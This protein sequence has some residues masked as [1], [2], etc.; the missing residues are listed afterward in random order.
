MLDQLSILLTPPLHHTKNT[1]LL[2]S[3][4]LHEITT[5]KFHEAFELLDN[6]VSTL[7]KFERGT[8]TIPACPLLM[9][10]E[11]K[12]AKA[13]V[14]KAPKCNAGPNTPGMGFTT[15]DAQCQ[16]SGKPADATPLADDLSGTLIYTGSN[17]MPSV[18]EAN[19]TMRLCA[20]HQC[21]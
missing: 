13:K 1:F 14:D 17:M 16:C 9:A 20:T 3:G 19:P 2:A 15:P 11:A 10:D 8:S 6:C 18:N 7:H 4:K 5:D 12:A 21:L